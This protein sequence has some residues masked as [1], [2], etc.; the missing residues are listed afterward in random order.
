M[1]L[2]LFACWELPLQLFCFVCILE[3]CP[4]ALKYL[5]AYHEWCNFLFAFLFLFA[6]S[7]L[8]VG[9]YPCIEFSFQLLACWE[10][11]LQLFLFLFEF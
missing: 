8:L 1:G 3:I 5:F 7:C 11:P 4:F 9:D 6:F 10:L 2:Q